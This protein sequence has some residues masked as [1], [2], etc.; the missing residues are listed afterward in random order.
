MSGI[1]FFVGGFG[2][3]A[4]FAYAIPA[5]RQFFAYC[6]LVAVTTGRTDE[7][8]DLRTQDDGGLNA[9]QR[10]QYRLLRSGE[11]MNSGHATLVEHG[12]VIA[13]K[14]NV[15]FWGAVALVLVFAAASAG[16]W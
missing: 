16:A 7:V 14:L 2:T 1:A 8:A 5:M 9:F 13:R 15:L 12:M 6:E 11:F 3:L 4:Y 10:E